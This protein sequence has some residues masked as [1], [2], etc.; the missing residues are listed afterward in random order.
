MPAEFWEWLNRELDNLSWSDRRLAEAA[1][2]SNSVI[3]RARTGT[4]AMSWDALAAIADALRQ[5]RHYILQLAGLLPR[6]RGEPDPEWVSLID[7]EDEQTVR[8]W[9]AA[10]KAMREARRKGRG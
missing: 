7:G 3:S 9:M 8:E 6:V 4:Q 10:I 1:G 2:L 5:P